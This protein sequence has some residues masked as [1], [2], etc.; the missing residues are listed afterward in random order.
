MENVSATLRFHKLSTRGTDTGEIILDNAGTV[1]LRAG[2][3]LRSQLLRTADR[4]DRA[5]LLYGAT[6]FMGFATVGT[7]LITRRKTGWGYLFLLLAALV[8]LAG[9]GVRRVAKNAP[10]LLDTAYPKENVAAELSPDGALTL[11][12]AGGGANKAA[13]RLDAGEFDRAQATAFLA[14][15]HR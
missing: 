13:I 11:V 3:G 4:V 10:R 2:E 7:T 15:L 9:G 1:R 14:A 6:A 12:L 5:T 8:A